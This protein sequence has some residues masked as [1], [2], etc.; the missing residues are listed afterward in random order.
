MSISD[1]YR[2]RKFKQKKSKPKKFNVLLDL[3]ECLIQTQEQSYPYDFEDRGG[4]FTEGPH[5]IRIINYNK[6]KLLLFLRPN[7]VD[8]LKFLF[9]N[10]NVGIWT[11]S[12]KEYALA[13]FNDLK[14]DNPDIKKENLICFIT[15]IKSNK[16]IKNSY[17]RLVKEDIFYDIIKNK[18]IHLKTYDNISKDLNFLFTNE[19]Y[20]DKFSKKNTLLIDD[21]IG[22]YAVNKGKN[23]ILVNEFKSMI[24]CDNTLLKI[25]DWLNKN[26][27]SSKKRNIDISKMNLPNYISSDPNNFMNKVNYPYTHEID[28]IRLDTVNKINKEC[29]KLYTKKK[30]IPSKLNSI[31]KNMKISKQTKTLLKINN[32]TKKNKKTKKTKNTQQKK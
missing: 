31:R 22:H 30:S 6:Q 13:I 10:F 1:K 3:D 8:F 32:K 5:N 14:G 12:R 19:A 2:F 27:I 4:Y 20:K 25:E 28:D 7:L 16:K 18:K 24:Y 15:K 17:G 29:K 11:S 9:D 23:V 26:I 21:S